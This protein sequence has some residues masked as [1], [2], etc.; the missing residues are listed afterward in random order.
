MKIL[1]PFIMSMMLFS[2]TIREH[3]TVDSFKTILTDTSITHRPNDEL[4]FSKRQSEKLN[5]PII[6]K[7]V[8][9]FEL[10]V[11]T[12]GFWTRSDLFI[13][14]YSQ[15]KWIAANYLFYENDKIIDSLH[16]I[17]KHATNDTA[18]KVPA[19]FI[20]DSILNLPSQIAIPGFR[21]NT[22]DGVSYVIE[23]VTNKF[24]K[25]LSYHNPHM[26]TDPYNKYFLRI[27]NFIKSYFDI[28]TLFS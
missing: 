9:S 23:I 28:T 22:A 17:T 18:G 1:F 7:G 10:R 21:D 27:I 16:L 20:Q 12:F 24:Y 6:V 11:W 4:A 14:R 13:L 15:N 2:C 3:K 25:I 26:F 5:I 19:Y 8:D